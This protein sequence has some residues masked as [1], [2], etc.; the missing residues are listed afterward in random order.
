MRKYIIPIAII[1]AVGTGL[2]F[3]LI[4]PGKTPESV[5]SENTPP[6]FEEIDKLVPPTEPPAA[7][8]NSEEQTT[9]QETKMTS[10]YLIT[11]KTSLGDISFETYDLDAPKAV[12]NFVSLARKSFYNGVIFHR[13][14]DGFMIQGGDPTGTGR[15]GP[16][17]SF[18]DEL[19][20]ETDSYKKG[21]VKGAVAMANSGPD[22]NGSQFFIMVADVPLPHD[23]TIFGTVVAGQDVAD[24]ISLVPRDRSDRPLTPV[25]I[26]E[27]FVVEK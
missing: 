26:N 19:N 6:P 14:I 15:G 11:L 5:S 8:E 23:Y 27:V 1:L 22:T 7:S 25:A 3:F 2:V 21:Y 9:E 24:K 16:G 10:K 4:K 20:P 18:E 13:V 12:D 17:Y